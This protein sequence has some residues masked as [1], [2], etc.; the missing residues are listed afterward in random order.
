MKPRPKVKPWAFIVRPGFESDLISEI[1]ETYQPESP[2]EGIVVASA[3]PRDGAGWSTTAYAQQAMET[4]GKPVQ[5]HSELLADALTREIISIY[6]Q[7]KSIP[8][9]IQVVS[10]PSSLPHD[11]RRKRAR[12]I[13][14]RIAEALDARLD[15]RIAEGYVEEPEEAERIAQIW[16]IDEETAITGFTRT[17][18]AVSVFPAGKPRVEAFADAP[19]KSGLKLQEAFQWLNLEPS[20]GETVVDLGAAP[21][22]WSQIML[23]YQTKLIAVDRQN[24]TIPLPKK[25]AEFVQGNVFQF[26]PP[27]TVDWLLID[28]AQRPLDLAKLVAKWGRHSWARQMMVNF[29]MPEKNRA[30][31]LQ[32]ITKVLIDAGWKGLKIRQLY[33][34]KNEVMIFG[35]LDPKL[36]QRGWLASFDEMKRRR[37]SAPKPKGRRNRR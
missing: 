10:P 33:Y 9:T 11:P 20:R 37:D 29:K 23:S 34:S 8:W 31:M 35:W 19:S 3:R 16:L 13:D 5:A 27:E 18:D 1:P 14:E 22:S 26:S 25:K 4:L 28:V 24:L 32:R 36:I 7:S 21:G 15:R 2:A 30:D 12:E 6:P 17:K